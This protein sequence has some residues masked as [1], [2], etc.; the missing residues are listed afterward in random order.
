MRFKHM[1][2]LFIKIL[3]FFSKFTFSLSSVNQ[4]QI[5]P[6]LIRLEFH[7]N[8]EM[9]YL[10]VLFECSNV[11]ASSCLAC[12]MNLSFFLAIFAFCFDE[13]Y[14]KWRFS[15]NFFNFYSN[16]QFQVEL[17]EFKSVN[18]ERLLLYI[19]IIFN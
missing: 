11:H 5:P 6:G 19:E 8:L 3:F 18:I 16:W 7:S 17:F 15:A 10:N 1:H 4:L 9:F 14:S 13:E 2:I 12:I